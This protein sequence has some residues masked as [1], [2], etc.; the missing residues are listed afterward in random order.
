MHRI[1]EECVS[2]GACVGACPEGAIKPGEPHV[3]SNRC[4]DCGKCVEVCPV[5]AI[6]MFVQK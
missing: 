6:V 2:C 1:T 3:I 5:E 4:T